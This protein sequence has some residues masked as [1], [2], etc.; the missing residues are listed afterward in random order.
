MKNHLYECMYDVLKRPGPSEQRL[1]VLNRLKA[2][3]VRLPSRRL[4]NIREDNNNTDRHD[5]DQ[6]M[7]YHTFHTK[8]WRAERTVHFLR[9]GRGQI[10]TTLSGIEQT[11]TTFLQKIYDTIDVDDASVKK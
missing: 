9:D 4:Q 5:G 1:H 11:L 8:R 2:K 3:I 10:H 6:S 7:I